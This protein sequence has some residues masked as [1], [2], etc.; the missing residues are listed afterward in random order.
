MAHLAQPADGRPREPSPSQ[1]SG[2]QKTIAILSAALDEDPLNVGLHVALSDTLRDAGNETGYLAHRIAAETSNAILAS[3]EAAGASADTL[4]DL[5]SPLPLYNLATSYFIRGDHAAALHWFEHTLRI[6][7][8]LAIAHQN[9][10]AVLDALARPDDAQRHRTRAYT[11]QR[12]Y[13]EA[14]ENAP[15]R[16]LILCSGRTSGNVP[17]DTLLPAQT[18]H[19]IKYAIDCANDVEDFQLPHYDLVFNAIGEPDVAQPLLKR[20]EAF[21]RRC[22]RPFLNRPAAVMPTQRHR[23]PQLLAD[24][25]DVLIPPCARLDRPP[26]SRDD[27]AAQIDAGRV[28]FP[29]L[30][31]PLAK[32]GGEGVSLHRSLDTLW[33]AVQALDAPCY[34][35]MFRNCRSA[36]GHFRKYRSIFIDRKPFPYHLA[37]GPD[38]MVHYFSAEMTSHAWKL[39]EERRF[40]EDPHAALGARAMRALEAIGQR[41]DLDY[42][43]I[44]FTLLDDGRVLVFEANATMLVHREATNGVL[45]H[46]NAFVERIVEAF[47]QMQAARTGK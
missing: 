23:L 40:L 29:L 25:D 41:L 6:D 24:I 26:V 30:L 20:L 45:A 10:A 14:A 9:V 12:V 46:K 47:G 5:R 36:D 1:D 42:A 34:L 27:L 15:R 21:A 17:F 22:G 2:I 19:R 31:R 18:S 3:A 11:L 39:D 37:I 44:D 7:P 33:P 13:V 38:W 8:D 43:G 32:H 35:T 28:G 4:A 16:V